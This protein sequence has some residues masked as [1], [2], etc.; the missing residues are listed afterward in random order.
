MMAHIRNTTAQEWN[1]LCLIQAGSTLGSDLGQ[2]LNCSKDDKDTPTSPSYM[3]P[4]A[5]LQGNTG[6]NEW[7]H[8]RFGS[9]CST[10][11]HQPGTSKSFYS[12]NCDLKSWRNFD[13]EASAWEKNSTW[14]AYRCQSSGPHT[15]ILSWIKR[16][17][18]KQTKTLKASKRVKEEKKG[19]E[20]P[21]LLNA[22]ELWR[23][24]EKCGI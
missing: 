22:E 2:I 23:R 7:N 8:T 14:W 13:V 21:L 17:Q 3:P 5:S 1:Y 16:K 9:V 20:C 10:W 12:I 19:G 6:N 18:N 11:A 15:Y 4:C 24:E